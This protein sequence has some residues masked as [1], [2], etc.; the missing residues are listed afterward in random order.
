MVY[1]LSKAQDHKFERRSGAL[2]SVPCGIDWGETQPGLS[3]QFHASDVSV[4]MPLNLDSRGLFVLYGFSAVFFCLFW[5]F[6][7]LQRKKIGKA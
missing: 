3:H 7:S 4:E 6:F 1:K 2:V 5:F